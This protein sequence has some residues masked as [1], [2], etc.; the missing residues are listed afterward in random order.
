MEHP[1]FL[2]RRKTNRFQGDPLSQLGI[3][4]FVDFAHPSSTEK[5]HHCEPAS[6]LLVHKQRLMGCL[7]QHSRKRR[8]VEKR[9]RVSVFI[10][11]TEHRRCDLR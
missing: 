9:L 10:Q 1:L 6:Y 2:F 5:P 4:Y 11:E 8:M 3:Q 7:L